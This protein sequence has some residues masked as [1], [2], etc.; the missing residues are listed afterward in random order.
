MSKIFEIINGYANKTASELYLLQN[1]VKLK[2]DNLASSRLAVCKSCDILSLDNVCQSSKGG[3]GCNMNV[4]IYCTTCKCP[5]G[6][7]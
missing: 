1:E 2:K 3:C 5:K 4:K 6:K 7:W